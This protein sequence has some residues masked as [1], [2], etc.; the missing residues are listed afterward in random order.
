MGIY[1]WDLI[2]GVI[3]WYM[4]YASFSCFMGPK[5]LNTLLDRCYAVV[6]IYRSLYSPYRYYVLTYYQMYISAWGIGGHCIYSARLAVC[7]AHTTAGHCIYSAL[8][9]ALQ[10]M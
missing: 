5:E 3:R 4:V 10:Y 1:M 7:T 8:P 2:L 9:Q 6:K